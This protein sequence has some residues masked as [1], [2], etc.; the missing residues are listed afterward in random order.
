MIYICVVCNIVLYLSPM[1]LTSGLNIEHECKNCGVLCLWF[2]LIMYGF[3][4]NTF[5]FV[6]Q[7]AVIVTN[8]TIVDKDGKELYMT[9]I[10]RYFAIVLLSARLD[11]TMLMQQVNV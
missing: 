10:A 5:V 2:W 1:T 4:L 7:T 8:D 11:Q 6:V 9:E 3:I